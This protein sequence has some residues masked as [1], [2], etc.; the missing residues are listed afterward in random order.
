MELFKHGKVY[1]FMSVRAYWI[2]FSL[3]AVV[4]SFFSVLVWPLPTYGTDFK[5]G[6]EVEVAFHKDIEAGQ[7]REPDQRVL[8]P[9]RGTTRR[10]KGQPSDNGYGC[11]GDDLLPTVAVG[12]LPSSRQ[13]TFWDSA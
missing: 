10:M 6:T 11:L 5:G 4:V 7:L 1:D 8:P 12:A 13:R 2:G 9:L 3:L